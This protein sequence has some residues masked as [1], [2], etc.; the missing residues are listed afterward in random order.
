[1]EGFD[2]FH[3]CIFIVILFL[4]HEARGDDAKKGGML[5]EMKENHFL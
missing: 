3:L 2:S 5:V 1:M 4:T